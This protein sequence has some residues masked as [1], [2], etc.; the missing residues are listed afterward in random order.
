MQIFRNHSSDLC[1]AI[2]A[3]PLRIVNQLNANDL[4]APTVQRDIKSMSSNNYDKAD[5]I[6]EEIRRQLKANSSP[7]DYLMKI[8][9]FLQKQ[10]DNVLRVIGSKMMS[11]L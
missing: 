9:L 3:D 2:E 6:V 5:K 7:A 10:S 8:C 4:I 1:D 11:Q